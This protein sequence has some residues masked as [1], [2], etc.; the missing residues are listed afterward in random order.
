[1]WLCLQLPVLNWKL[2]EKAEGASCTWIVLDGK[3]QEQ[4][5]AG[6]G[7]PASDRKFSGHLVS[8]H[9]IG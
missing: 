4:I 8:S 9:W 7:G 3:Q 1:M 2:K 5:K 6:G